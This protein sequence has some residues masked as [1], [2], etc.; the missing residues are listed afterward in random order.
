[1]AEIIRGDEPESM[2][3]RDHDDRQASVTFRPGSQ[4]GTVKLVIGERSDCRDAVIG[5]FFRVSRQFK[6]W[7]SRPASNLRVIR[8][9][10]SH[11]VRGVSRPR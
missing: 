8:G 11:L 9:S 7:N 2:V 3:R 4:G 6:L 1:M 10:D 5:G